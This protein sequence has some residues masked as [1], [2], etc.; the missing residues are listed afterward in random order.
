MTRELVVT[1]APYII[2]Y[3]VR[4]RRLEPRTPKVAR[5]VLS[6]Q[7]PIHRRRRPAP[8]RDRP[9]HQR[10]SPPR[11]AGREDSRNRCLV[12]L[13]SDVAPRIQ[14]PPRNSRLVP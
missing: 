11:I 7:I 4:R 12:I 1:E 10:L 6:L 8:L 13:S 14:T 3:R 2:P 9:H 5:E